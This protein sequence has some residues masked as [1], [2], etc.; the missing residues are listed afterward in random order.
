MRS[1]LVALAFSGLFTLP[2]IYGKEELEG[3]RKSRP[4]WIWAANTQ[5]HEVTLERQF[6]CVDSITEASL[7]LAADFTACSLVL[8]GKTVAILDDYGPMLNLDVAPYLKLGLNRIQ[9][10]ATSKDGPAAIALS[11]RLTAGKQIT[12]IRSDSSWSGRSDDDIA[13][14]AASRG[15]VHP[16][17]WPNR[18]GNQITSFD[19]YD[20]WKLASDKKTADPPK[21]WTIPGFDI[22][23]LRKATGDEGSWVRMAFDPQ[24]RLT[25]SREDKG[26]LR[27]NLPTE[28]RPA[29]VETVNDTLLECRGLLYAHGDLYANANNSKGLYRLHD[30]IGDDQFDEVKLLREF[31]GTVGHGRN[32]L[33]LGPDGLIYSIH[34][35]SVDVPQSDCSDRTSPFR[36]GEY[37]KP[38]PQGH[39]VRTDK[40]GIRWELVSTG[41][42]NP[43]GL[44]F[45]K[46][47]DLFTYDA[48]AEFDMG[49]P[50]YRPTRLDQ[51]TS[52][53]DFGWRGLTKQWPPYELDHAGNT[54][55]T[56]TIGKGSP[57]A[58]QFGTTSNFPPLWQDA[59]FLLDWAYGRI[60]ACHL[61]PR[62]A[63]YVSRSEDF[64]KGRPLNVTDLA[65]GP[66]GA[67]Y[68]ITGGRK[69]ESSLY[70]IRWT[71]ESLIE[72]PVTPHQQ[73]RNAFSEQQRALRRQLERYHKNVGSQDAVDFVWSHLSNSDPAIRQAARTAL[74]HQD[75]ATWQQRALKETHRSTAAVALLALARGI[76]RSSGQQIIEALSKLP[77]EQMSAFDQLTV[78]QA[79]ALCLADLSH[80]D[81]ASTAVAQ[82]RLQT[83]LSVEVLHPNKIAPMGAGDVL[84][85]LS[86][87]VMTMNDRVA[88]AHVVQ[89]MKQ[90]TRQE[91]RI[92]FLFLLRNATT[93]WKYEDRIAFFGNLND[94]EQTA[95]GGDG[96]P[97][98]LKNIRDAAVASLSDAERNRLGSLVEKMVVQDIP[99]AATR[100]HV[101][102]WSAKDMDELL[103]TSVSYQADSDRGRELFVAASCSR[104]HRIKHQGG[105]VGPDLTS[106]GGRFSHR[107]LLKSILDPSDVVSEK[108]RNVQ[109]ITTSGQ[110]VVGQVIASGD[111]RSSTLRLANNPLDA[112]QIIDIPKTEIEEHQDSLVSPMPKGLLSTFTSE[113]ISDLLAYLVS[114]ASV[115]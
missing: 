83:W 98:F 33:A 30:S 112:S 21:V 96:M 64:A 35:D 99:T 55:P 42:R 104:C 80:L 50:W 68:I 57:T 79:W 15:E 90:A 9:T 51:V 24:G 88:N 111:Y 23:L 19:N 17:Y 110:V 13:L 29:N 92:L 78:L 48:D 10:T 54:L 56:A 22:D 46:H 93:G 94:L 100:P 69:T 12:R 6:T 11:L 103:A 52:G 27:L 14:P 38:Q 4:E 105:V 60:V 75:I 70:R 107:D 41:L 31:P 2:G 87:L 86:R 71:G 59:L 43:Y 39:V 97:G 47:G 85:K 102:D 16:K 58:V 82:K 66:D 91:D 73:A 77:A 61:L 108:Y 44:D 74:E 72:S 32:D 63:G 76:G 18:N 89:L 109:V 101:R 7:Q 1:L 65:F 81:A 67:M 53:S 3:P 95:V 113:D 8:N 84:A 49:A 36:D 106:V 34:G 25:I 20:Q 115:E 40:D 62:G 37:T 28:T 114:A 26:L 45:N 5:S